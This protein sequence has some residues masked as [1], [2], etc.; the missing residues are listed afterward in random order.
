MDIA[1]KRKKRKSWR[2]RKKKTRNTF[3]NIGILV[4]R[5][6]S[7]CMNEYC[8][9]FCVGAKRAK[10]GIIIGEPETTQKWTKLA[11]FGM[12]RSNVGFLDDWKSPFLS[13]ERFYVEIGRK[14][15]ISIW[16]FFILIETNSPKHEEIKKK[17]TKNKLRISR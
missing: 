7:A 9:S 14:I 8:V 2:K 17:N 12:W 13:V 4:S 15:G 11:C 10:W 5:E 1:L 16:N 3:G 6:S